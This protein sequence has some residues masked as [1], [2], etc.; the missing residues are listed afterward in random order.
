MNILFL[1]PIMPYE[2]CCG[3]AIQMLALQPSQRNI[4]TC[5]SWIGDNGH[6]WYSR[7]SYELEVRALVLIC[8]PCIKYL[9]PIKA[10]CK[11]CVTKH[12]RYVLYLRYKLCFP[13]L[14]K[15]MQ[16]EEKFGR[17]REQISATRTHLLFV[18]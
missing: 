15:L 7:N 6:C 9:Y 17:T 18:L 11:H 12:I 1:L 4:L 14:H 10:T 2:W 13:Y 8:Q 5:T 3:I 16:T